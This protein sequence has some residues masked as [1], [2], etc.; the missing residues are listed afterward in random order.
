MKEVNQIKDWR[1]IYFPNRTSIQVLNFLSYFVPL[2]HA[3][4]FD[5]LI[6]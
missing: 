2:N 1:K 3:E 5:N 4:H 6:V